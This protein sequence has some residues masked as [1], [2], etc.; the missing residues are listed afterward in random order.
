MRSLQAAKAVTHKLKKNEK[1]CSTSSPNFSYMRIYH[2]IQINI[3]QHNNNFKVLLPSFFHVL[4]WILHPVVHNVDFLNKVRI[5]YIDTGMSAIRI[6]QRNMER[7]RNVIT[8]QM[9]CWEGEEVKLQ[10]CDTKGFCCSNFCNSFTKKEFK[11]LSY[12]TG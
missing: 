6:T 3:F 4:P 9:Y 5:E 7:I 11:S 10:Y 2:V 1:F 12:A 8:F